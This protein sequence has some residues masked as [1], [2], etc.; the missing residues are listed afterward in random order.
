M[1]SD[2]VIIGKRQF[3]TLIAITAEEA[4]IG[5]M[6]K[7]WP[8]P[9]MAFPFA[10][11]SIRKFWMK[12]TASPLDIVFCKSGKVIGI[13]DGQPLSLNN[14]GPDE[15][16]DLVVEFPGGTVNNNIFVGD[17]VKILYSVFTLAKKFKSEYFPFPSAQK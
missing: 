4:A 15:P 9:V 1:T 3:D 13:F 5:L 14:V 12:N 7:S 6:Y 8:P 11:A 2:K 10:K 17:N 16:C